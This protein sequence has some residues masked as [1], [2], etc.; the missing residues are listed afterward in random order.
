MHPAFSIL[1]SPRWPVRP[2]PGRRWRW[3]ACLGCRAQGFLS[4]ALLVAEL[5]LLAGAGASFLHLGRKLRAWRAVLMW[6]TSWMS[7][8][9]I[10]LPAFIG[11]WRCGGWPARRRST[12]T[13][14]CRGR[15]GH[16]SAR[17]AAVVLHRDDLRLPA[18]HRGV[19][20]PADHR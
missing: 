18:F 8:E 14:G 7:R 4:H 15:A 11:W 12:E 16:R 5:L 9:V 13:P 3:P 1:F 20:T 17:L 2:G 10:V 19:G 6:R